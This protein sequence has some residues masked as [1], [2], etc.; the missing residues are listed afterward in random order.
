MARKTQLDVAIENLDRDIEALQK[1][2]E[3][4]VRQRDEQQAKKAKPEGTA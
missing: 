1:A 4:L 2:R 3:R